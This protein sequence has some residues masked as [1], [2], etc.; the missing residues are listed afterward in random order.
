MADQPA[1]EAPALLTASELLDLYARRELSPVEATEAVLAR[2]ARFNDA[3]NAY[4]HLA[5]EQARAEARASEARWAKGTPIGPLDGVTVGIKDNLPVAGMPARFGSRLTSS[6]PVASDGAAVARLRAAGAIVVGK[7]ATPE[8]GWKAVTDS[9]LTGITRNPWNLARTPGGSTGGGAAATVLAMGH[10]Q[11]G[12]DGGGSLRVP[13]SFSGCIGLKPTRGRV[14]GYPPSPLGTLFHIGPL[15]RSVADAEL[16]LSVIGAPDARDVLAWPAMPSP[17]VRAR[18]DALRGVRIGVSPR[19]GF[20]PRVEREVEAAFAGAVTALEELGAICE[21]ADPPL[22]DDPVAVWETIWWAT[23]AMMLRT[24]GERMRTLSDPGLVAGAEHGLAIPASA[25]VAAQLRRTEMSAA[26]TAFHARYDLLV[27]PTMP[28]VAFEA[29]ALMPSTGGWGD[30]WPGWA[31]FCAP[32][33]LTQQPAASIPCGTN[34]DGLPIGLQIVG[35]VGGDQAVL[36]ACRAI[37][38]WRPLPR[39]AAPLP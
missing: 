7:T 22:G 19:L 27:T 30:S 4:C 32:F 16:A 24:H 11:I 20:A 29:G 12:T 13:A 34:A 23:A 10:L 21:E 9:P 36:A 25:Y 15:A 37:E 18:D 14:P 6:D 39:L 3:V 26:M 17:T 33:N 1:A 2:I 38:S 28:L 5:P 8:F 31:P 35:P